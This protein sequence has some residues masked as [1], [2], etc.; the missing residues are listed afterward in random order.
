MQVSADDQRSADRSAGIVQQLKGRQDPLKQAQT[1]EDI[2]TV[3]AR[4][5]KI[6]EVEI[7]EWVTT[8][9]YLEPEFQ[10]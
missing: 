10:A 2:R 3:V 6:L 4:T 5:D 9:S 1:F 7:R 8:T